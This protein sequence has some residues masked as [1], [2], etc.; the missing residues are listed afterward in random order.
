M[1]FL[2]FLLHW[3]HS[4][5][6]NEEGDFVSCQKYDQ[7]IT[8]RSGSKRILNGAFQNCPQLWKLVIPES[9][10]FIGDCA[11]FDFRPKNPYSEKYFSTKLLKIVVDPKNQHFCT[12][13][14]ILYTKNMEKLIICPP[15]RENRH[16]IIP[17]TVKI[18]GNGAFFKSSIQHLTFPHNLKEIGNG[19]FMYIDINTLQIP[20]PCEKIGDFA[21]FRAQIKR[22]QL[23]LTLK[24]IGDFIV[25]KCVFLYFSNINNKNDDSL[26]WESSFIYEKSL[27][28]NREKTRIIIASKDVTQI[29]IPATVEVISKGAFAFLHENLEMIYSEECRLHTIEDFAFYQS[30]MDNVTFPKSLRIIG[31]YAFFRFDRKQESLF[32]TK[33]LNELGTA[34]FSSK[35]LKNIVV[36]QNNKY[37]DV[38]NHMNLVTKDRKRIL[39]TAQCNCSDSITFAGNKFWYIDDYAFQSCWLLNE[40]HFNN[41]L[42]SIGRSAFRSCS[43][44]KNVYFSVKC[45]IE[46]IYPYTFCLCPINN[47]SLPDSVKRIHDSSFLVVTS[48][49]PNI[50]ITK[51]SL[52]EE[53]GNI[54]AKFVY[55]PKYVTI[56]NLSPIYLKHT[57]KISRNNNKIAIINNTLY[58]KNMERLI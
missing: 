17:E 28:M 11:F 25:D 26:K 18:L 55:I 16:F 37:F 10:E 38:Y 54:T 44:L 47:I 15:H 34:F 8:I 7:S 50:H 22:L 29:I 56:I 46:D 13:D 21:F 40:I 9:V 45:S 23:P 2:S 33:G 53:I 24:H 58:T 31:D 43:R 14:N 36:D 32:I 12:V 49:V 35:S 39:L 4:E 30:V 48:N 19:C 20:D 57:L 51:N 3:T 6:Y 1:F 52:L 42:K 27:L 5:L 41:N